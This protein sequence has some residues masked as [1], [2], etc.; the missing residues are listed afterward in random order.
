MAERRLVLYGP[1][2]AEVT[3]D[4]A[5]SHE[6]GRM[7]L[8]DMPNADACAPLLVMIEEQCSM[9]RWHA[10]GQVNLPN[11]DDNAWREKRA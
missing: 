7:D 10:I 8:S 4:M 1:N 6:V 11:W 5:R 2:G 9:G 3:H